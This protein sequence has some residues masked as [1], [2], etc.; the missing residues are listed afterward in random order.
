[1][2]LLPRIVFDRAIRYERER[3]LR[4]NE[5]R[6]E[7]VVFGRIGLRVGLRADLQD[8][9]IDLS[10][11]LGCRSRGEAET[12][13]LVSSEMANHG[14]VVC[15]Q[16]PSP[17]LTFILLTLGLGF[18]LNFRISFPALVDMRRLYHSSASHLLT[19]MRDTPDEI[20]VVGRD[21]A[22]FNL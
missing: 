8:P 20:Q 5:D 10:L 2:A 12:Y 11:A 4:E 21:E 14:S 16:E 13:L 9:L 19:R 18:R 3:G 1:M 22:R 6:L 15:D 7:A 17:V